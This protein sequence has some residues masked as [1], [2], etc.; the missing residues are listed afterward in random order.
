MTTVRSEM[1]DVICA[2]AAAT[3]V[4]AKG[5]KEANV[6]ASA[7]ESEDGKD[8]SGSDQDVVPVKAS[9]SEHG[10]FPM[11]SGELHA[12]E[13]LN[14][15]GS[16]GDGAKRQVVDVA[17]GAG[18][19]AWASCRD[20]HK[21]TGLVATAEHASV[22]YSSLVLLITKEI[23]LGRKDGF[24]SARFLSESRSLGSTLD[25]EPS[26]A[27]LMMPEKAPEAGTCE[28]DGTQK[29]ASSQGVSSFG[30]ANKKQKTKGSDEDD[31]SS[32]SN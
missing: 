32:F 8:G 27:A 23:I 20:G 6:Q 26:T 19:L 21:Y 17:P 10:L 11:G 1:R 24:S 14:L 9:A 28:K 13:L 16:T 5:D 3:A 29:P 2:K 31:S 18:A 4:V 25:S 15:F 22:L 12:R 30:N 7:S